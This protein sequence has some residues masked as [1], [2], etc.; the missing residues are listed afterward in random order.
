M[1]IPVE[2]SLGHFFEETVLFRQRLDLCDQ[3]M[4]LT[5]NISSAEALEKR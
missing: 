1:E 3:G 2:P 5:I 4:T